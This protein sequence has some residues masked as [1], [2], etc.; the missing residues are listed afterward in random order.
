MGTVILSNKLKELIN[1]L[2]G[3][4]LFLDRDGVINKRTVGDYVKSIKEFEFLPGV[5]EAISIFNKVF[6]HIIIVTNQQGIA[7]G[8][9]SEEDLNEVHE[10]LN[11]ELIKA[12]GKID[13]IYFCPELAETMSKM[14]K[15]EIGMAMQA[16]KDFPAIDLNRSIMIGDTKSD[17]EFAGNAGMLAILL[18]DEHNQDL[19]RSDYDGVTESLIDF[20]KVLNH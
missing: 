9:M 14:R 1:D 7:K 5:P 20:A 8:V 2:N 19:N 10:H 15:P 16:Q 11:E 4:T 13:K 17:M 6:S 18:S 12:G 3:W